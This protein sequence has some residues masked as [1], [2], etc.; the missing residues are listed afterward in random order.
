MDKTGKLDDKSKKEDKTIDDV[1]TITC[2]THTLPVVTLTDTTLN[3]KQSTE[4]RDITSSIGR[5]H[6]MIRPSITLSSSTMEDQ[7]QEDMTNKKLELLEELHDI[8]KTIEKA[9]LESKTDSDRDNIIRRCRSERR[10]IETEVKELSMQIDM[11]SFKKFKENKKKKEEEKETRETEK[12]YGVSEADLQ[13]LT[14]KE[15]NKTKYQREVVIC[16]QYRENIVALYN[17]IDNLI[18]D[19]TTLTEIGEE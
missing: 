8:D 3:E 13:K 19:D 7:S 6:S 12:Q 15:E 18:D 2:V 4:P 17:E 16:D 11:L 10:T 14:L 9:K 5:I 1:F